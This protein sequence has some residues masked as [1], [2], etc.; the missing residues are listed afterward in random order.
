MTRI[1]KL[2]Y[3]KIKLNRVFD[4][5]ILLRYFERLKNKTLFINIILTQKLFVM[6]LLLEVHSVS[7][8]CMSMTLTL[9]H[10]SLLVYLTKFLNTL[11][12]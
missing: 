3:P 6:V 2:R 12:M 7:I 1:S 4:V 9:Y 5:D 11:K 10:I 8:I